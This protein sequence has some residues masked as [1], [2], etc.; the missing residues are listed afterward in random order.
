MG[1]GVAATLGLPLARPTCIRAVGW[2]CG[3]PRRRQPFE[4]GC[5]DDELSLLTALLE[6]KHC[7]IGSFAYKLTYPKLEGIYKKL[8]MLEHI[9]NTKRVQ[10]TP[11]YMVKAMLFPD[12]SSDVGMFCQNM[13]VSRQC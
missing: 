13:I 1:V 11:Q 8:R 10:D 6:K 5:V 4:C 3:R 12:C 2:D 9:L 7:L